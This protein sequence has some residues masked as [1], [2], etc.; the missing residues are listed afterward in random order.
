MQK[1]KILKT[2]VLKFFL[3]GCLA[4]FA[5][6][7]VNAAVTVTLGAATT[8]GLAT[9]TSLTY[10]QTG[11]GILGFSVAVSGGSSTFSS[12][13]FSA[14]QTIGTYFSNVKLYSNTTN[15]FTTATNVTGISVSSLSSTT[16]TISGLSQVIN[17]A[18][19]YYFIVVDYTVASSTSASFQLS[20]TSVT[21]TTSKTSTVSGINYTLS[22]QT[23]DWI[24]ATNTTWT[25][26]TNWQNGRVPGTYDA[27][28]IAVNYSGTSANSIPVVSASTTIASLTFG[29]LFTSGGT[30]FPGI[31]VNSGITLTVTGDISAITDANP[32]SYTYTGTPV[33]APY[34]TTSLP[35]NQFLIKGAGTLSAVNLNINADYDSQA[36]AS[37]QQAV[38]SSITNL[39]LSGDM[40]LTSE[41][42]KPGGTTYNQVASF[43]LTGGTTDV[44]GKVQIVNKVSGTATYPVS[45][46]MINPTTSAGAILQLDNATPWSSLTANGS[47]YID[48]NNT[49][50]KVNYAGTG[51]TI[52]TSTAITGLTSGLSYYDLTLSGAGT[53]TPATGTLTVLH[54]F[55]TSSTAAN[56]NTN[57]TVLNVANNASFTG[58]TATLGT[59]AVTVTGATHIY[60]GASLIA[61]SGSTA[62]LTLTGA[63]QNDLN[64]T[65]TAGGGSVYFNNSYSNSGTFTAGTGTVYFNLAG[66]QALSDNSTAGTTFNN[67]NFQNSGTKTMSGTGGFAVSSS[68]ILTMAGTATLAAAGVL[69]LKS[70]ATGSATVFTMPAGT[71]IT[72]NVNV[73]RFL[74][75]G[76]TVSGGRWI[77]RN[78]RLMSSP[79]NA[80]LVSGKYPYTINYIAAKAI[81][82][83]AKSSFGTLGG[84]P[85][86]YVYSEDYTPSNAS[87]TG[88]NFKGVTDM[89]TLTSPYTLTISNNGTTKALYV[90]NGF[91]FFFRGD[92]INSV[93]TSPG[94]TTYPYVAPESVVFTATGNLNQGSYTVNN[95]QTG[96]GL[97]FTTVT[98]NSLIQGFNLVGNPYAS[99]IDWET[100]NSGGIVATN[101][102]PSIYVFNPVTNQYNTYSS[103]THVGNPVAFTGKIAS[104]QG[105][106]VKANNT[107]PS[108]VFNESAK[109]TTVINAGSGNL[110]M[111][112]PAGQAVT[113]QLFRLR[114][115]IDSL[116]YDDIAIGFKS[117]A[118]SK[119]NLLEDSKYLTGLGAAEGLASYS[120]DT[121]PKALSINFLPLP[122]K[123]PQVIKLNVTAKNSGRLTL[124]K[125]QL[126]SLPK[127]YELW[128]IDKYKKDSLD[129]R[130]NRSYVFDID[131]NDTLSFGNNRFELLI[132]QNKLRSLRLRDFKAAK[133]TRGA[134]LNWTTENEENYTNFT[135]ERSSDG[136]KTFLVVGGYPSSSEGTYSL[137]DKNPPVA[138]DWYRLKLEDLNGTITYSKPIQLMYS[139]VSDNLLSNA[140]S[141]Y[142]NPATNVINVSITPSPIQLQ[143]AAGNNSFA[144]TITGSNGVVVK[145]AVS[146]QT[147]W[148]GAV[149]NLLPGSYIVQ[150]INK[151]NQTVVG[152]SKFVKL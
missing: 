77:Y 131:R 63:Y 93:G 98:G 139:N 129:I 144:I 85:T 126:D 122:K 82:S 84:N 90:G 17:S 134:Q 113:Q 130:T 101:V 138:K 152:K 60:A 11:V 86:I 37:T 59:G 22:A 109:T 121:V 116:N 78:Y 20:L 66:A 142:P 52:T 127:I 136:G 55:T 56:F 111:G 72:G 65:F 125:T 19:K 54:D 33:V 32:G 102:N 115:T 114:L 75:G 95:W 44:A 149:G 87:F 100:V 132:R 42:Y 15:S 28:N 140:V 16:L 43:Y 146:S 8:T 118:S 106:F 94:K 46:L 51:Q 145:N 107:S 81:V 26:T 4:F 124:E 148:Q 80:G 61:G 123:E 64:G 70:D 25:T 39:T 151:Q 128:L 50:A 133:T 49:Y 35:T 57:N 69:T 83:G 10:N 99:T 5:G 30:N 18:T 13:Q 53:Q 119:Y 40:V 74:T 2:Q 141:V 47:N 104:G 36:A 6:Q 3:A 110:M 38:I 88:G 112:K 29:G 103:S 97:L 12:F 96:S 91:M 79:V 7:N 150:V 143:N 14:T 45:G 58:G 135:I 67:V 62:S 1:N 21:G 71:S 27:V 89:S 34:P 76:A 73:E 48:L 23:C 108:L 68:G 92:K 9:S 147:D 31:S 24:G 137:L 117:T 120:T 41:N 105:F